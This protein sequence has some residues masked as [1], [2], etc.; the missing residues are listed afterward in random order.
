MD[1]S[2][3]EAFL[4]PEEEQ[5]IV[6]AILEA[7]RDTSGEIRVHLET[8]AKKDHFE[9]AKEVFHLLK[10]DNT[11]ERNGVLLY[12]AVKD[13][14]FVICGDSGINDVVPD[15]F[16]NTTK[17]VIQKHFKEGHFKQGII[18]GVLMAGKELKAHFPWH[19]DDKNELSNEVSRG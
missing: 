13:H 19:P 15:N 4:T 7:E 16:W 3:V 9:R 6:D 5:Q 1:N 10:M 18:E 12:V 8:T 2:Q 14:R 17:D 11:R